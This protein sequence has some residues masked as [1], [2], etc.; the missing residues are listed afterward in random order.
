MVITSK[1]VCGGGVA[2]GIGGVGALGLDLT[3][4]WDLD[5]IQRR[6]LAK[7]SIRIA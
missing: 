5:L 7:G 6:N 3:R 4:G 1:T 2:G